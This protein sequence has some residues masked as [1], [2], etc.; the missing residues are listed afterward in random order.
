LERF[1]RRGSHHLRRTSRLSLADI[2]VYARL[3]LKLI[4]NQWWLR[5]YFPK[6]YPGKIHLLL[7]NESLNIPNNPRLKWREFAGATEVHGIP[8]NHDTITGMNGTKI[9]DTQ[10]KVL[11]QRL[12]V[13]IDYERSKP[14]T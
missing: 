1:A 11:A 5:R 8:G 10:I 2:K 7:T 9:E 14:C 12:K 3:R 4:A 13:C 6:A